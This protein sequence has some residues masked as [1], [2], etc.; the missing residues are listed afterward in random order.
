MSKP[1]S[2]L[3]TGRRPSRG[4]GAAPSSVDLL[5]GLDALLHRK[6]RVSSTAPPLPIAHRRDRLRARLVERLGRGKLGVVRAEQVLELLLLGSRPRAAALT[7]RRRRRGGA[8][9]VGAR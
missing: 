9:W 6:R 5:V 8:R 2:S 4:G 7:A 3:E 1:C